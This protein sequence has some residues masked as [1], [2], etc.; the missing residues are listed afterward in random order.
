MGT[1]A[2]ARDYYDTQTRYVSP[3]S[4]EMAGITLPIADE[5]G[6]SLM[7]NPAAMAKY[8]GFKAEPLNM[9][10]TAN[11]N[12]L[13][14]LPDTQLKAF[15]LGGL[16]T[17][18]NK[19]ANVGSEFGM[20]F[21]NMMAFS[22]GGLG[23]GLLTQEFSRAVSDGTND[24]YQVVSQMV[25]TVGYGFGIA[26]NIIR[27]GYSLQYVN[28]T[29][30]KGTSAANSSASFL[31]GLQ[32]GSGLS[33]N[34]SVDFAFPFSN[35]PTFSVIA[36]N[37]G[38]LHFIPTSLWP[39]GSFSTGAPTD[40]L[41]T[42]DL[43]FDFQVRLSGTLKLHYYSEYLDLT[44]HDPIPGL[45]YKIKQGLELNLSQ[46]LVLR[47]G[48]TGILEKSAGIAYRGDSSEIGL[49][50]YHE[51]SPYSGWDIRYALQYKIKL[52]TKPPKSKEMTEIGSKR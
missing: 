1:V 33:H 31:Q 46:S 18:M 24:K 36:R 5:V 3:A 40:E 27:L 42:V 4:E 9:S 30:G 8:S 38:G 41:M 17:T 10:F 39:R 15:S 20:G 29:T 49:A 43:S 52:G 21:S 26:R 14:N 2:F 11:S 50:Y 28:E 12:T 7:N 48:I 47:G 37:L 19:T 6:N 22:W 51:P 13:G 32:K 44:N 25:P 34:V 45:F 16:S 23:I 35:L